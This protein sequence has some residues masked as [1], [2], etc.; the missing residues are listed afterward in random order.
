MGRCTVL[1]SVGLLVAS[2]APRIAVAASGSP[3][4]SSLSCGPPTT[5]QSDAP[6]V[7]SSATYDAANAGSAQVAHS[8]TMTLRVVSTGPRP[9]WRGDAIYPAGQMVKVVFYDTTKR[10]SQVRLTVSLDGSGR[11]VHVRVVTCT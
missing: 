3:P 5:S 6:P 1:V 9:G 11:Y 7:G 8:D 2:M 4:P 10:G